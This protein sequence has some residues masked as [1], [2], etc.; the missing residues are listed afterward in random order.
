MFVDL[1]LYSGP[2]GIRPSL[3]SDNVL[4]NKKC[5]IILKIISSIRPSHY[6]T[7]F[8]QILEGPIPEVPLYMYIFSFP[9][10]CL[11]DTNECQS[12]PCMNGG[13]CVD[14]PGGYRCDCV[15]GYTDKHCQTDIDECASQPCRNGA[16]CHDLVN[17]YQCTCVHGYDGI[18]C[19][20]NIDDCSPNPCKSGGQ[21]VDQVNAFKCNCAAGI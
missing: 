8:S 7:P 1:S 17:K 3:L 11:S 16:T 4:L 12:H 6:M 13:T 21:C 15:P 10:T 19:E 18:N 9:I 2:S 20:N 14:F 5:F